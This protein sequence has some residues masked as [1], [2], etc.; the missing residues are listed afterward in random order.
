MFRFIQSVP[1]NTHCC[2]KWF[3]SQWCPCRMQN[4]G[5]RGVVSTARERV[6]WVPCVQTAVELHP[7]FRTH[8][9]W[10]LRIVDGSASFLPHAW[11]SHPTLQREGRRKVYA[12]VWTPLWYALHLLCYTTAF[13]SVKL[14]PRFRCGLLIPFSKLIEFLGCMQT[15]CMLCWI[16]T[17]LFLARYRQFYPLTSL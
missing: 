5:L 4:V 13:L 17:M 14:F 11:H 8:L 15:E 9:T 3:T 1:Q 6:K 2:S 7:C 16:S 10:L 12:W